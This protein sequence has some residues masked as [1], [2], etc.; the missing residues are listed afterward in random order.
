MTGKK[1]KR[2]PK[3]GDIYWVIE[4]KIVADKKIESKI[5]D[6]Y[7]DGDKL[8]NYKGS[9][10]E[11]ADRLNF[12]QGNCFKTRKQAEAVKRRIL[13]ELKNG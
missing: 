7:V 1:R 4:L 8:T 5:I 6:V 9:E 11:K 3:E 10:Y 12:R 2:K 13:K